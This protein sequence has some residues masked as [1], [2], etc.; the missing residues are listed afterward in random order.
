MSAL[1]NLV[2]RVHNNFIER[3]GTDTLLVDPS[4]NLDLSRPPIFS[5]HSWLG[6]EFRELLSEHYG[7]IRLSYTDF[8]HLWRMMTVKSRLERHELER[9]AQELTL[10]A[11]NLPIPTGKAVQDARELL[12]L[13]AVAADYAGLGRLTL[14]NV[15][16]KL[17]VLEDTYEIQAQHAIAPWGLARYS[18]KMRSSPRVYLSRQDEGRRLT[19][20]RL[21]ALYAD[22]LML[23]PENLREI[24][25]MLSIALYGAK[26]PV[27]FRAFTWQVMSRVDPRLVAIAEAISSVQLA[28]TVPI[29]KLT[30]ACLAY[31]SQ[32]E[33]KRTFIDCERGYD[34]PLRAVHT[35]ALLEVRRRVLADID[36]D[37]NDIR[38]TKA[39]LRA[40]GITQ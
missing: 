23:W 13:L 31:M 9:L 27:I 4:V 20:P 36:D 17:A 35:R 32:D 14:T 25:L 12:L 16:A 24:S 30:R 26:A 10:R 19:P 11:P 37:V 29:S 5:E 2:L 33:F 28:K 38:A 8:T 15:S 22:A 18:A 34:D 40:Q 3:T 7:P 1:E 39:L 6:V 21:N